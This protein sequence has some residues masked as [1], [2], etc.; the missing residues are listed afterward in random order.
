[1][2]EELRLVTFRWTCCNRKH[3]FYE[4]FFHEEGYPVTDP[5]TF[6]RQCPS[7]GVVY[8]VW[9]QFEFDPGRPLRPRR[10]VRLTE[11]PP[12]DIHPVP[13]RPTR[14]CTGK[15]KVWRECRR[16]RQCTC[17]AKSE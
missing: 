7:C 2:S 15:C 1:M 4:K 11:I 10:V 17:H 16:C 9:V 3:S 5:R 12:G 14:R 8:R 6:I 13:P